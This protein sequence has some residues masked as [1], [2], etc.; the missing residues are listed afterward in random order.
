MLGKSHG[1]S[2]WTHWW[3]CKS[4]TSTRPGVSSTTPHK[5]WIESQDMGGLTK[6]RKTT[7]QNEF[8][9]FQCSKLH[10]KWSVGLCAHQSLDISAISASWPNQLRYQKSFL[11]LVGCS[12]FFVSSIS[13]IPLVSLVFDGWILTFTSVCWLSSQVSHGFWVS[14]TKLGVSWNRG[15]PSHHPFSIGVFPEINQ[16]S[17]VNFWVPSMAMET[18]QLPFINAYKWSVHIWAYVFL[19]ILASHGYGKYSLFHETNHY[20]PSLTII[21]PIKKKLHITCSCLILYIY[22]TPIWPPYIPIEPP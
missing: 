17:F 11:N 16:R 20:S 10:F 21:K 22:I 1:P 18:S 4:G 3:T 15:T 12:P 2:F 5:T 13:H 6:Q 7:T 14:K 9:L 8:V 19:S